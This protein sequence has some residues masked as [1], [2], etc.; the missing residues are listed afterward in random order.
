MLFFRRASIKKARRMYVPQFCVK[1][2]YT[3]L[4]ARNCEKRL[5]HAIE[6][7]I[8]YGL[9]SEGFDPPDR[10]RRRPLAWYWRKTAWGKKSVGKH[11]SE[12]LL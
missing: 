2:R 4:L 12:P 8:D 5:V 7:E 6:R 3:W 9:G 11:K 10:Q 1:A